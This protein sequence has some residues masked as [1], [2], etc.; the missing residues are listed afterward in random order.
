MPNEEAGAF[1]LTNGWKETTPYDA[2]APLTEKDEKRYLKEKTLGNV[3]S[4][5]YGIAA[6]DFNRYGTLLKCE[7]AKE[8]VVLPPY[9]K[10][11]D[12]NLF[13]GDRKLREI[14]LP[15]GLLAIGS[16]CFAGCEN[17]K[18]IVFPDSLEFIGYG[19]LADL[20][21]LRADGFFPT[22]VHLGPKLWGM[23]DPFSYQSHIRAV[24]PDT[25]MYMDYDD[26]WFPS[27]IDCTFT[28]LGT[29]PAP[30]RKTKERVTYA[31]GTDLERPFDYHGTLDYY[32]VL[33]AQG[34]VAFLPR[35][36]DFDVFRNAC[37]TTP[38]K[39]AILSEGITE[40]PERAFKGLEDLQAVR[41]PSTLQTIGAGAFRG[42]RQLRYINLRSDMRIGQGAFDESEHIVCLDDIERRAPRAWPN[43]A[44]KRELV[45][46]LYDMIMPLRTLEDT[47][48]MRYLKNFVLELSISDGTR[49]MQD[50][51]DMWKALRDRFKNNRRIHA[52][53]VPFS[54]ADRIPVFI[55]DPKL[56]QAVYLAVRYELRYLQM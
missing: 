55:S 10:A 25:A 32:Q 16:N 22:T 26:Q 20:P 39:K 34:P 8:R 51:V 9:I 24:I 47:P 35:N 15:E 17:L 43:Q 31:D 52:R 53:D 49:E 23:A 37:K 5:H 44:D 21:S 29:V 41:L 7:T 38:F 54:S 1:S 40:I 14:V 30:P 56:R 19:A 48:E 3:F 4:D 18:T 13:R 2:P 28:H 42:C 50:A 36:L 27:L 46:S 11:L 45:R 12:K 33:G 6:L